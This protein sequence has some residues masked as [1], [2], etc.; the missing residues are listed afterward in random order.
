M[1][2]TYGDPAAELHRR[3]LFGWSHIESRFEEEERATT[4]QRGDPGGGGYIYTYLT[5]YTGL[6]RLLG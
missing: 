3:F 6:V 2:V 5:L 4:R 1:D